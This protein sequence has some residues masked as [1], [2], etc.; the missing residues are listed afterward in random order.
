M[1][2]K[3]SI[4]VKIVTT[5]SLCIILFT[6]FGLFTAS[7]LYS[8]RLSER[9]QQINHQYISVIV[10]Q[11]EDD[12]LELQKLSALCSSSY[13]IADTMR[14]TDPL[15]LASKSA[16]I[17]AQETLNTLSA[18]T[19]LSGYLRHFA[20]I[21]DSGVRVSASTGQSWSIGEWQKLSA[22][23]AASDTEGTPLFHWGSLTDA[24]RHSLS[25]LSPLLSVPG[26]FLYIELDENI[27]TDELMPYQ[28]LQKLFITDQG[29]SRILSSFALQDGKTPLSG[30]YSSIPLSHFGLQ[31]GFMEDRSLTSGD[32]LYTIYVLVLLLLTT[33]VAGVLVTR[34][35]TKKITSPIQILTRHIRRLSETND[36][37]TNPEIEVSHDEIGEIGRTVNQLTT[38]IQEL[39]IQ[40]EQIYEQKKNAEISLLQSQINPHFLYNTLDSIRWMAVIQGSKNIEHTTRALTN[41]LRNMAKSAGDKITLRE[42]LAL[43]ADY[44][45]IQQVRYVEIFDYVCQ[46]PEELMQYQIIKLTLQ[47]IV[48]N[49]ILH[50]IEPT[51]RFGQITISGYEKGDELYLTI[52]DNGAGMTPEEL[53]HLKSAMSEANKNSLNG[54]GVANVD[55]RLKLHYGFA[56]GLIY[57]S[58]PGEFTRVT[59]HIPKEEVPHV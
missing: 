22:Y 55:A 11:L 6:F 32:N 15:S 13:P 27:L 36:F 14:S 37:T 5:M 34:I 49:A 58:S 4:T 10:N 20:L 39:L 18:S 40:Q 44:V 31:V 50:G 53:E 7:A 52:E 42:A 9:S 41:L 46:V 35:L 25:Y 2:L 38:H 33:A 21:N 26:S 24:S 56:Y 30:R 3:D 19:P 12:I 16:C 47:P 29:G 1:K 17:H 51:G 57:E 48:E 54:I 8:F 28:N 45:H 23:I 59:V 43:V